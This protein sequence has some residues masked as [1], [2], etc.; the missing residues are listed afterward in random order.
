M[1]EKTGRQ[2]NTV[3]NPPESFG[4]FTEEFVAS[5][6]AM[7]TEYTPLNPPDALALP[8]CPYMIRYVD[9]FA[10]DRSDI[11][12]VEGNTKRLF[13]R[14][15]TYLASHLLERKTASTFNKSDWVELGTD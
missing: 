11:G 14:D 6:Y 4:A 7:R 2:E 10:L 8:Q 5:Q 13:S 1:L 12:G 3:N 15:D 9:R